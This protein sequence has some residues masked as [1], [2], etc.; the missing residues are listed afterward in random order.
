MSRGIEHPAQHHREAALV[1]TLSA[2]AHQGGE[3]GGQGRVEVGRVVEGG[4][5]AVLGDPV[6]GLAQPL[7]AAA[8]QGER[9]DPHHRLVPE[10]D[11]VHA[12]VAVDG[13][14]LLAGA[15][16][17]GDPPVAVGEP[18]EGSPHLLAFVGGA[19]GVGRDQAHAPV[20]RVGHQA[21]P[22]EEPLLVRPEGEVVEGGDAVAAHDV[23]GPELG[24][25]AR[26]QPTVHHRS[27]QEEQGDRGHD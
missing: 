13:Q 23:A 9:L 15:H 22:M 24:G 18:S 7:H 8:G 16:H 27:G 21:V 14:P 17:R 6:V 12:R 26:G 25:P 11:V 19:D 10:V 1:L 4:G 5:V 2:Q 20:D 3:L